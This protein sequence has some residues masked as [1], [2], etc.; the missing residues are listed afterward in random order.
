[1]GISL[2]PVESS[3]ATTV[4]AI[5]EPSVEDMYIP[6]FLEVLPSYCYIC[7]GD[8]EVYELEAIP[9]DYFNKLQSTGTTKYVMTDYSHDG[10]VQRRVPST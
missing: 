10:L 6:I 2:F 5:I 9:I 3:F 8:G 7:E 1:V 4:T